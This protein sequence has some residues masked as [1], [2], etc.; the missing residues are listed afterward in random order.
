MMRENNRKVEE[1]REELSPKLIDDVDDRGGENPCISL[2][3]VDNSAVNAFIA[4]KVTIAGTPLACATSVTLP[5]ASGSAN[6]S[7]ATL[8]SATRLSAVTPSSSLPPRQ[9]S[10]S[11]IDCIHKKKVKNLQKQ[12]RRLKRAVKEHKKE[13][14]KLRSVSAEKNHADILLILS[15][16]FA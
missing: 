12:V 7:C 4:T 11:C 10:S 6:V 3:D 2:T 9:G 8:S 13:M 5:A 1:I 15:C 16:T 14:R